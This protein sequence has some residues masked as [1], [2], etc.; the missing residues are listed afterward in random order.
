MRRCRPVVCGGVHCAAGALDTCV[1]LDGAGRE[2][3]ERD[4]AV[5]PGRCACRGALGNSSGFGGDAC[6]LSTEAARNVSAYRRRLLDELEY[7]RRFQAVDDANVRQQATTL[8]ALARSALAP[9]D[10]RHALGLV[11]AVAVDMEAAGLS[12]DARRLDAPR[13]LVGAAS[14]LLATLPSDATVPNVTDE[15]VVGLADDV[16]AALMKDQVGPGRRR[17][18][19]GRPRRH[20]HAPARNTGGARAGAAGRP[21]EGVRAAAQRDGLRAG[22]GR[23]SRA[24]GDLHGRGRGRL[25]GRARDVRHDAAAQRVGAPRRARRPGPRRGRREHDEWKKAPRAAPELGRRRL[26]RGP[27]RAQRLAV[28]P[29]GRRPRGDSGL[30]P[31]GAAGQPD[32]ELAF[33]TTSRSASGRRGAAGRST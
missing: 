33:G 14:S 26:G 2:T 18:P 12:N 32:G 1:Y 24:G 15:V 16:A 25:R 27:R 21:A 17:G 10:A 8:D 5:T 13:A 29:R 19:R 22:L 31:H 23:R 3:Y 4:R 7:V 9:D 11:A 30:P 28:R 20:G 6:E